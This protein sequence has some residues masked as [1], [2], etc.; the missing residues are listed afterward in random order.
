MPLPGCIL[1]ALSQLPPST[2]ALAIDAYGPAV[3]ALRRTAASNGMAAAGPSG[4]FGEPKGG[5][6]V[7]G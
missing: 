4:L 2:R 3:A 1:H 6:K 7:G 5:Q